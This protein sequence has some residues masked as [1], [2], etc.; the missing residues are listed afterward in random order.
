MCNT[1]IHISKREGNHCSVYFQ[2]AIQ[3]ISCIEFKGTKSVIKRF[4]VI[5]F[6][7]HNAINLMSVNSI[8]KQLKENAK[9][10]SFGIRAIC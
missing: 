5:R 8:G 1:I 9:R 10:R 7:A 6:K 4:R 3:R 2:M